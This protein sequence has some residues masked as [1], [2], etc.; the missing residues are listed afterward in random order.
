M[1]TYNIHHAVGMDGRLDLDRVAAVIAEAEADL[2]GLQE[3][4]RHYGP[5]SDDLDQLELLAGRL[6]MAGMFCGTLPAEDCADRPAAGSPLCYG[7]A[8]LTPHP[9]QACQTRWLPG[10]PGLEPRRVLI[11]QV[12]APIGP[13]RVG[14]SH[15]S[16]ENG[17][18]RRS[19]VAEVCRLLD[20]DAAGAPRV[21]MGDFNDT[22]HSEDLAGFWSTYVDSW[23]EA[24]VGRGYTI[25]AA[26]PRKRIDYVLH[27]ASL[28]ATAATTPVTTAS[29]HRPVRVV[30]RSAP[31]KE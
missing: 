2:I 26:R 21:L 29:D 7:N 24:G 28:L 6:G 23:A 4:D 3:V 5:R 8:L 9:V 17:P 30:L 10:Q 13:V 20:D 22:P 27:D 1:L 11:A 31:S 16:Y 14:V 15:L 19:Q 18:V 25:D 12:L